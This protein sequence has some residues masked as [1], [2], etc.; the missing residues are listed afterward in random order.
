MDSLIMYHTPSIKGMNEHGCARMQLNIFVLQ[1]NLK[2]IEPYA[3]LTRSIS[4]F[5]LFTAGPD[6][7]IARAKENDGQGIKDLGLGY[8][9]LKLLIELCYSNDLGGERTD[10]A[11]QAKRGL[12]DHLLQLSECMYQAGK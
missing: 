4:F 10:A 11:L 8:D 1:Q 9:E 2:N 5:D 3:S 12:D 6:A 7:I